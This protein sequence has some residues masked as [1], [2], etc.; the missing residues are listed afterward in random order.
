MLQN[1]LKKASG[2]KILYEITNNISGNGN[3]IECTK[4]YDDIQ[5]YIGLLASS[6]LYYYFNM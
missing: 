6:T 2:I 4:E 5:G 3:C 1:F